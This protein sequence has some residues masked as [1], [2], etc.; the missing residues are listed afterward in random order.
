MC[1]GW[2]F[3]DSR[4]A[5]VWYLAY[6]ICIPDDDAWTIRK[7][8]DFQTPGSVC[9]KQQL[10]II[11]LLANT[12]VLEVNRRQRAHGS[13]MTI[14][15]VIFLSSITFDFQDPFIACMNA[16]EKKSSQQKMKNM[17]TSLL[18]SKNKNNKIMIYFNILHNLQYIR[19]YLQ[20]LKWNIIWKVKY[21]FPL[22]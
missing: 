8:L 21:P 13:I 6:Q 19:K 3:E 18:N 14:Y 11:F 16:Q 15:T 20:L 5:Q 9:S 10:K 12:F 2:Q 22:K 4:A 17:R 1:M 7:Q